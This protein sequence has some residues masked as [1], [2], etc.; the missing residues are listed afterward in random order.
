MIAVYPEMKPVPKGAGFEVRK[1]MYLDYVEE[2]VRLNP[3]RFLPLG[4]RR[5]WWNLKREHPLTR[6][7]PKLTANAEVEPALRRSDRLQTTC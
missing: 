4:M 3:D 5:R 1:Q 6:P 2:L 7:H